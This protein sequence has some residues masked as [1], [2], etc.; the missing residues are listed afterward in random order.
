MT[1]SRRETLRE[2]EE[3]SL[4]HVQR[5]IISVLLG[6]V[7]GSFSAVLATYLAVRGDQDLDRDSVLGLWYL[8]GVIGLAT[9]VGVLVIHGRRPY[10]PWVVLGLL[11]MAVSAYWIAR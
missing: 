6:V 5:L 4:E 1:G 8:S 11:P 9:A 7:M 2:A 10:S 3:R